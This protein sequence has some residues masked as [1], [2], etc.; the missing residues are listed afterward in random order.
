MSAKKRHKRQAKPSTKRGGKRSGAGRPKT[1]PDPVHADRAFAGR[2]IEALVL[3]A[4][5]GELAEIADWRDLWLAADL[6]IR[7]DTRKFWYDKR[8]GK[9]IHTVNHLHDKPIEMNVTVS[10]AEAIQKARKRVAE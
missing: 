10:L 6:R 7:L 1:R 4:K 5:K 8:D 2:L 3:P 9:A